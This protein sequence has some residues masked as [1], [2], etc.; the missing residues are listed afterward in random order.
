MR[1][2]LD[3]ACRAEPEHAALYKILFNYMDKT[4]E[5]MS[6]LILENVHF[7]NC[8][9]QSISAQ[10]SSKAGSRPVYDHFGAISEHDHFNVIPES[11]INQV[12]PLDNI[13]LDSMGGVQGLEGLGSTGFK[14]VSDID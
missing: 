8:L 14:D 9:R 12:I 4:K 10:L 6:A 2:D 13:F 1:L 11:L 7:K 5:E 3:N